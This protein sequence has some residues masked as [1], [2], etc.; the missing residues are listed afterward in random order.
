LDQQ[1]CHPGC[2]GRHE[3]ERRQVRIGHVQEILEPIGEIVVILGEVIV[4]N[5][6]T[7]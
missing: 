4:R 3:A 5:D 2:I 6:A 7:P 1:G